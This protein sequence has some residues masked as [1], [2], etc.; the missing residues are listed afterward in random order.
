MYLEVGKICRAEKSKL[1]RIR[2]AEKNKLKRVRLAEFLW[3]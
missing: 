1:K 2:L 3:L